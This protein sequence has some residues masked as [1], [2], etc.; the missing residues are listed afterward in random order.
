MI[1][2]KN[3]T[4]FASERRL[5]RWIP[6]VQIPLRSPWPKSALSVVKSHV[7][8]CTLSVMNGSFPGVK[9]P[10]RDVDHLPPSSAEVKER[11]ELYLYSPSG[12]LWR[13][14]GW[15]LPFTFTFNISLSLSLL[16][17]MHVP[18]YLVSLDL[19]ILHFAT[20]LYLQTSVQISLQAVKVSIRICLQSPVTAP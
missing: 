4:H 1:S 20:I 11:V 3:E 14:L 12:P 16:C 5:E 18:L 7:Y 19:I 10:G 2:T 8:L 9:W 15:T 6:R 13:V 17:A